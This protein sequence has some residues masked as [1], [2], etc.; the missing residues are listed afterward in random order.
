MS[1]AIENSLL[2]ALLN[3]NSSEI[4]KY[5]HSY[6]INIYCNDNKSQYSIFIPEKDILKFISIIEAVSRNQ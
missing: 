3:F 4:I 1:Y 6:R 5:E 2:E